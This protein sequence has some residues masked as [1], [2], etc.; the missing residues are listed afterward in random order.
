MASLSKSFD[1]SHVYGFTPYHLH[2]MTL[3]TQEPTQLQL[4]C[5]KP[6]ASNKV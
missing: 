4:C 3:W 1:G 5:A 6:R 2:T